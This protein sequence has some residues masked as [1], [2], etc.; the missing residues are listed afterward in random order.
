MRPVRLALFA[1]AAVP[2]AAFAAMSSE[3]VIAEAGKLPQQA[4][5]Q[6]RT[7]LELLQLDGPAESQEFAELLRSGPANE[8]VENS[9]SCANPEAV[10]ASAGVQLV[11]EILADQCVFEQLSVSG[12]AVAAVVQCPPGQGMPGRVSMNGR[13]GADSLDLLVTV[14]QKLPDKGAMRMKM[15]IRSERIG[16]CA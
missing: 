16:D 9:D 4:P 15:R 11:R 2:A 10:E 6:Y 8:E 14:E 3:Q 12:D 13:I 1:L 5:G 7:S